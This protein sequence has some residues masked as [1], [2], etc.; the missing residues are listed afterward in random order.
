MKSSALIAIASLAVLASVG[1]RADE[2]DASQYALKFDSSRARAE[3]M[4]EARA[5]ARA[6]KSVPASS[7]VAP[8]VNSTIERTAVRADAVQA[9]RS[10]LIPRGEAA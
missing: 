3:V 2:A 8:R 4:A 6:D 5:E 10:G 7:K 9:L 1:A